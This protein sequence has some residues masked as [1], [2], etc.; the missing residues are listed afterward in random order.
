M[1][2]TGRPRRPIPPKPKHNI[3]I[4][5]EDFR[6][7]SELAK[8]RNESWADVFNK[9]L[10]KASI[11]STDDQERALDFQLENIELRTKVQKI[12]DLETQNSQL[13]KQLET[14]RQ[15]INELERI[16]DIASKYMNVN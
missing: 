13:T 5:Q 14:A 15:H 10:K 4:Y 6:S 7:L 1:V 9:I 3:N 8:R 2:R 11:G 16:R 12:E